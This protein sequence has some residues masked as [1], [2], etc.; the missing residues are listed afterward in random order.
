[1]DIVSSDSFIGTSMSVALICDMLHLL[2]LLHVYFQITFEENVTEVAHPDHF[3]CALI[4]VSLSDASAKSIT[5]RLHHCSGTVCLVW[6]V[7]NFSDSVAKLFP[8]SDEWR[9]WDDTQQSSNGK[10]KSSANNWTNLSTEQTLSLLPCFVLIS[11]G[12]A[13]SKFSPFL[14]QSYQ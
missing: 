14:Q 7:E 1:M 3:S 11:V 12:D 4:N 2:D 10:Q 13:F 5:N 6:R 9:F 8:A